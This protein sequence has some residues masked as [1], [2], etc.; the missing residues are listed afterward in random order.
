MILHRVLRPALKVLTTTVV[1]TV[2]VAGVITS[3][4]TTTADAPVRPTYVAPKIEQIA[5]RVSP[6]FSSAEYEH[7]VQ[8]WI[9]RARAAHGLRALHLATCTD[10][11]A[12]G[13]SSHL[14][15]TNE[16]YHQ[17]MTKLLYKC[18]A[19]Y[20]AETL[21]RGAIRPYTLVQMWMHSAPHRHVL[22]SS[23]PRRI[24]IGATPNARGE[25]VVA[26]NFMRF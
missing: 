9:N 25:W 2:A 14:A 7:N 16:F 8:T 22:M 10:R 3:S 1:T 18:N 24:G 23:S 11:V 19:Y 20:A 26:A 5:V 17:S 21:G 13:W 6:A 15:S 12:E 4:G